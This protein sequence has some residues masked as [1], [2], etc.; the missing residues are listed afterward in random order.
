MDSHTHTCT[1][2]AYMH[3]LTHSLC[4]CHSLSHACVHAHMQRVHQG[5]VDA[6]MESKKASLL[7]WTI[8]IVIVDTHR[9]T[10]M[11]TRVYTRTVCLSLSHSLNLS[12]TH[13][14]SHACAQAHTRVYQ[15]MEAKR[16]CKF[17]RREK[18]SGRILKQSG[19]CLP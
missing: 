9:H 6:V 5:S 17:V 13:S 16:I 7:S 2:H 1:T 4:L 14:H 19:L 12:L 18:F 8:I 10:H 11:H 15:V 3:T